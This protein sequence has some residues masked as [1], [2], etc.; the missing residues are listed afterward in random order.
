[1]YS[2][3][4]TQQTSRLLPSQKFWMLS[5]ETERVDMGGWRAGKTRI[6]CTAGMLLSYLVPDN[7]GFIG[8]ASGKDLHSTTIPTFFDEVCPSDM[9]VGRPRK[10]GQSGL[11]VVL[12]TR[13]EGRTS[14]IYF[15]YIVDRQTK[16]SHLAG[17][18]WGF[19]GVD[20]MEEIERGDWHK[21]MGRLSRTFFDPLTN[22]RRPIRTHALGVGNQ[23]GHDWI[24]EDW[25][26]GGD[27]IFDVQREPKRYYKSVKKA[28][29]LG[30]IVRSEENMMSNGGFVPDEY[31]SNLRR[32]MPPSWCARY[33][34]GS[35][36]DFSGKIY[37]DYNITSVHNIEPFRIPSHWPWFCYVDPGGSVPWGIG[38]WRVDEAGN[39][40]LVNSAEEIYVKLRL[41][42]NEAV[43]WIRNNVPIDRCRFIIDYQN[44]PVMTLFQDAGIH[45]EPAMKDIK[46]GV[47][48]AM[49]E[50]YVNPQTFL[51]VWYKDTQPKAQWEKFRTPG[52]PRVWTFNTCKSWMKEHDNYIWD[53]VKRN[54]PKEGQADHHCD[55]TR[56]FLASNPQSAVGLV[57]DPYK[58]FRDTDPTS[59]YHLDAAAKEMKRLLSKDQNA[60][61]RNQDACDGGSAADDVPQFI[62]EFAGYGG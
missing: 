27:Y 60:N 15:D 20:Q 41:N 23:M 12:K 35:F 3:A 38:V 45:C 50:F 16:K 46:V 52:A 48:G 28:H 5:P 14:K 31:F 55:G 40:I 1:M 54:V 26:E 53:P 32:S 22:T 4:I 34:D 18:N 30:V 59:A 43:R 11:E 42:P 47:N 9:I 44:I 62:Q 61:L 24:F 10:V 17:G 39:K 56:Y 8:R 2:D 13:Y 49:S 58:E 57:Q 37:G 36:D 19:F 7:F 25:F 6:L 29:R 51:P 33:M 21:L